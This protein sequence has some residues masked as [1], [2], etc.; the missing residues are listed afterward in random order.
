MEI[1]ASVYVGT[2]DMDQVVATSMGLVQMGVNQ[3]LLKL[4]A[5]LV[6]YLIFKD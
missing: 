5:K 4:F 6:S 3:D 1:N 2:V